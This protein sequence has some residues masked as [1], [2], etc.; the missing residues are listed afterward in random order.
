MRPEQSLLSL[1]MARV[2][3]EII[4]VPQF[5]RECSAVGI[6]IDAKA[7]FDDIHASL[8]TVPAMLDAIDCIRAEVRPAHAR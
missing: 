8:A 7:L 2:W 3:P 5:E 6:S 4:Y 1:T